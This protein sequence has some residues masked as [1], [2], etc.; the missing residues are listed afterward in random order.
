MS[1]DSLISAAERGT[2][3]GDGI[4]IN[5]ITKSGIGVEQSAPRKD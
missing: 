2:S 4:I 3:T 1:K 5:I